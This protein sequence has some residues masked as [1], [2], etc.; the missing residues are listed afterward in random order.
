MAVWNIEKNLDEGENIF[1]FTAQDVAG[2]MS[3]SSSIKIVKDTIGPAAEISIVRK[4]A[5]EL[6]IKWHGSDNN[7]SGI[8]DYDID[9]QTSDIGV[10]TSFWN[11]WKTSTASTTG[12]FAIEFGKQYNFRVRAIDALGNIGDW[13]RSSIQEIAL[14]GVVINEIAWAGTKA[15][16]N[17]EWLEL[18]NAADYDFDA[19]GWFFTDGN[20]IKTI[21]ATG[22]IIKSKQYFLMERTN[23]Q[24]ISDI[25][26]D[27]IF[28]G[29]LHNSGEKLQLKDVQSRV[30]DEVDASKK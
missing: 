5:K 8:A 7:G 15:N 18:Y 13:T 19:S 21:F 17:D 22:T 24:T 9:Y 2:N 10:A 4:A 1:V 14:P 3:A 23:D 26:A 27:L 29:S 30:L 20:D 12:A 28:T 6:D 11:N 25:A 16:A